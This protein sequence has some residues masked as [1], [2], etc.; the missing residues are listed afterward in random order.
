[1]DLLESWTYN[2]GMHYTEGCKIQKKQAGTEVEVPYWL[3]FVAPKGAME[4]TGKWSPM[5]ELGHGPL[6]ITLLACLAS[7]SCCCNLEHLL[8]SNCI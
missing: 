4:A 1:M 5:V 2:H 8:L 7:C 6:H 3:A